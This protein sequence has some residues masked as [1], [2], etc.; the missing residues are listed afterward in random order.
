MPESVNGHRN[1]ERLREINPTQH[2]MRYDILSSPMP[3]KDFVVELRVADNGDGTSTVVW[4]GDFQVTSADETK[5]VEAIRG[6]LM[7]GLENLK[8]K[9]P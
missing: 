9:Y 2:F 7:A 5:I 4:G 1:V 3:I 8:K 6:F